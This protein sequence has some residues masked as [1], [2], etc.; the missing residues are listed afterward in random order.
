MKGVGG[1]QEEEREE[2]REKEGERDERQ[3]WG[4]GEVRKNG[5]SSVRSPREQIKRANNKKRR[6]EKKI[7][8]ETFVFPSRFPVCLALKAGYLLLLGKA[9]TKL[10]Q[11]LFL[12]FA[13]SF[14]FFFL[15]SSG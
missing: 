12:P 7:E 5:A 13:S 3:E 15:H 1:R 9:G 8:K 10:F 14:S 4:G 6:A 11:V 2:R